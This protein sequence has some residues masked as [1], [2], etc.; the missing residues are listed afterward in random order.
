MSLVLYDFVLSSDAYKVRLACALMKLTYRS[1]AV[2][3]VPGQA[4]RTPEFL[5]LNPLGEVP[6]LM[7][8]GKV[9]RDPIAILCHLA[10][11]DNAP[12]GWL[13]LQSDDLVPV[14]EWL[15]FSVRQLGRLAQARYAALFAG[16]APTEAARDGIVNS[17]R[18]LDDHLVHREIDGAAWL[19][20]RQP[21]IADV[22]VFPEVALAH[23]AG[24]ALDEMPALRR[25]VRRIRALP[26]FVSMPGVPSYG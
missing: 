25:W 26:G 19:A 1:I 17:L 16:E 23:D 24:F 21:T 13:P 4:H 5:A 8:G 14:M 9:L 10:L 12:Q 6:V 11:R 2:D 18:V 15:V 3:V 20:T 22:A 7:D